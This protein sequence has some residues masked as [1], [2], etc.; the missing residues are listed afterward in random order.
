[1]GKARKP[2]SLKTPFLIKGLYHTL[3]TI[4]DNGAEVKVGGLDS[5]HCRK[6]AAWLLKAAD[7]LE[8]RER[9]DTNKD[10]N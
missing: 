4:K 5:D 2:G 6:L 3:A 1:M 8:A 7:W 9:D 10:R